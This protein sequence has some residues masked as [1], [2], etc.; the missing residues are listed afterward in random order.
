MDTEHQLVTVK[1]G[2]MIIVAINYIYQTKKEAQHVKHINFQKDQMH[3][4]RN[5]ESKLPHSSRNLALKPVIKKRDR[6]RKE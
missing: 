3:V 2:Y 5:Q 1:P 4:F 6:R